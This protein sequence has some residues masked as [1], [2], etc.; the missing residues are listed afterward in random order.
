MILGL[1]LGKIVNPIVLGIIFLD[2]LPNRLFRR[3]IGKDEV[4]KNKNIN[5]YWQLRE[6]NISSETLKINFNYYEF[7]FRINWIFK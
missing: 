3:I 2:Y 6:K 4:I 1:L 7:Y 5:S